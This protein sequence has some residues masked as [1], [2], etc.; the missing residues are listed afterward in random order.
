MI[1][2]TTDTSSADLVI[3]GGTAG[4]ELAAE[5]EHRGSRPP[6]ILEAGPD[7]GTEHYRWALDPV[8]AEKYWLNPS[9]DGSFWR[10]YT[11]DDGSFVVLSGLRHRLGGRK[12]GP[13]TSGSG[14]RRSFVTSQRGGT[15]AIPSRR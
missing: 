11:A 10:P 12:A 1:P 5:L 14:R 15:E 7:R 13:L 3:G 9:Y 8:A 6:L 4:L 2:S